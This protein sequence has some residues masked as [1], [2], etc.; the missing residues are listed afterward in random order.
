MT[1]STLMMGAAAAIAAG[2]LSTG[3]AVGATSA[4]TAADQACGKFAGTAWEDVVKGTKGTQYTITSAGVG[5]AFAKTWAT[6]LAKP[7]YKGQPGGK[8]V[9][10]AGWQCFAA[11][12]V[13]GGTPG[14]CKKSI[15][16][17]FNWG[18]AG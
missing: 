11:I 15:S 4:G 5:C 1:R 9:G 17:H 8:I 6:K 10:P 7:N 12:D 13:A 3:G 2:A 14:S 16:V 18:Y